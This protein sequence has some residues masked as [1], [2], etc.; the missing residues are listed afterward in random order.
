MRGLLIRLAIGA[1]GLWIASRLVP[2]M[3]IEG[4]STLVLA[5]F[6]LGLVNAIVRPLAIVLTF[7]ITIVTL[8]LFLLIVNAGML[9]LVAALLDGFQLADFG[10]ALWGSLVVSLTSWVANWTIG[11]SGRVEVMVVERRR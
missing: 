4:T 2:G 1:A 6:L 9:A 7:P 3:S 5:A 10:S 11:P 8:G